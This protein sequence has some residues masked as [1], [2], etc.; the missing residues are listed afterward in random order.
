[1]K[2]SKEM[3]QQLRKMSNIGI[4][5]CKKALEKTEGDIEK[6]FSLLKKE[7][8]IKAAENNK[9]LVLS[10][11]LTNVAFR[12]NKAVLFELNTET[13]FVARN[14]IFLNL[15]SQLEKILLEADDYIK[16]LDDFLNY[17]Y[18]DKTVKNFILESIAVLKEQIILKRIAIFYKNNTES[19]GIYKHQGGRIS[20]L[21]CLT[22]PCLEVESNLPIHI[23]GLK[24]KFL[25]K[26]KIDRFFLKK[27]EELLKEKT[28]NEFKEQNKTL[29]HVLIEK[30]VQKR[31]DVFLEQNCLLEQ[32]LYNNSDQKVKEY[33]KKYN[34]DVLFFER[35]ELGEDY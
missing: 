19:F 1:M 4:L 30:I 18:N 7:G 12:N 20:S 23:V 27:E 31:L 26:E 28:I 21:V 6:A 8:L 2:I 35:F 29:N 24:P 22:K 16:T 33:L 10:E 3:I 13:D 11:G 9:D 17:S 15:C 34:V 32:F 5:Y 14:S 25:N